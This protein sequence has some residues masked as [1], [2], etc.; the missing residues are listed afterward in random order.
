MLAAIS[1]YSPKSG[2]KIQVLFFLVKLAATI[3][4]IVG[5]FY[6]MAEG[7]FWYLIHDIYYFTD[8]LIFVPTFFNELQTYWA[9]KG[10]NLSLKRAVVFIFTSVESYKLGL[11]LLQQSFKDNCNFGTW[12]FYL[13]SGIY[14][15]WLKTSHL[16][17]NG[18]TTS[19]KR[20]K[21][22]YLQV[23]QNT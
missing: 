14:K 23:I 10:T 9:C 16:A 22:F 20:L 6:K 8:C 3:G 21:I 4:I 15:C 11:D 12:Y 7:R 5:G 18:K 2:S 17:C 1:I 13:A 19:I